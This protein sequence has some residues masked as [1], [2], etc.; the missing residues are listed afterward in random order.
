MSYVITQN[1][2]NTDLLFGQALFGVWNI[3]P[4]VVYF[5]ASRN[6][7][8]KFILIAPAVFLCSLQLFFV[9][10]YSYSDSSTS[11]LIFIFAPIYELILMAIGF[12]LGN[13]LEKRKNR[14]R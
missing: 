3:F 7:Q 4:H 5:I 2:E 8:S 14:N 12:F 6:V 11:A 10:D 1:Y 9:M 13:L